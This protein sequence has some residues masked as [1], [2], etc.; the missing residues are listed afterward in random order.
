[1]LK[2]TKQTL[3]SFS[4]PYNRLSDLISINFNSV[5]LKIDLSSEYFGE[6]K[7]PF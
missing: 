4:W 3:S 5:K 6:L 7:K 2:E 1:M